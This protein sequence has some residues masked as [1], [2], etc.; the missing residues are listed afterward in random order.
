MSGSKEA[1]FLRW[2]KWRI[3]YNLIL[4]VEGLWLLRE[5]LA[6]AFTEYRRSLFLIA[7]AAN[8]CY[9]LGPLLEIC[10]RTLLR[11]HASRA[12][13]QS[14]LAVFFYFLFAAGLL[15]SMWWV[16]VSAV[17]APAQT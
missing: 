15:F 4:L 11:S 16:W 7:I 6:V 13:Y 12:R 10:V 2:E 17:I 14:F 9:C 1:I 8:V 3:G 5:Y